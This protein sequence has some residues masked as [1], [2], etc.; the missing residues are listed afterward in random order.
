[1]T[2]IEPYAP[3]EERVMRAERRTAAIRLR[4]C[5]ASI[6]KV[7]QVLKYDDE[8]EAAADIEDGLAELIAVPAVELVARQQA[9]IMDLTRAAYTAAA[10]GD[11]NSIEAIRRLMEYQ[12]K[13]FGFLSPTRFRV[14][15]ED[16]RFSETAA[17]LVADLGVA[18]TIDV[19]P[20]ADSNEDWTTI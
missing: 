8:A 12:A 13:L 9:M 10:N 4:N 11:T 15:A 18:T 16:T 17:A 5:G 14:E 6:A 3:L 2:D 1:M 7:A 20:T 19:G